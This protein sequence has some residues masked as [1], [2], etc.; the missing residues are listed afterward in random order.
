MGVV[1]VVNCPQGWGERVPDAAVMASRCRIGMRQDG[2]TS[3]VLPADTPYYCYCCTR[4]VLMDIL[5]FYL[6]GENQH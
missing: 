4:R 2:L 1:G 3:S 5:Y 6:F